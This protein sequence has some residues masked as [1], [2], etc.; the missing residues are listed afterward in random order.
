MEFSYARKTLRLPIIPVIV[1][2]VRRRPCPSLL[3][4]RF[5]TPILSCPSLCRDLA[6]AARLWACSS[7]ASSMSTVRQRPGSGLLA[8]EAPRD[9]LNSPRAARLAL[10]V[11]TEAQ[12]SAKL[13]EVLSRLELLVGG[14]ASAQ[15]Y[16]KAAE[17]NTNRNMSSLK[18]GDRVERVRARLCLFFIVSLHVRVHVVPPVVPLQA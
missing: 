9:A 7:R 14:Q 17:Q 8:G 1:G 16:Q 15:S 18:V 10:P 2:E 11:T 12:Q 6:G 5:K 13:Q 4:R 3:L